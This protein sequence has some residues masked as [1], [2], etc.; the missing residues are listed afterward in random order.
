MNTI[1]SSSISLK[2]KVFKLKLQSYCK[3]NGS[4]PRERTLLSLYSYLVSGEMLP[5]ISGCLA[6]G[7]TPHCKNFLNKTSPKTEREMGSGRCDPRRLAVTLRG[8]RF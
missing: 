8:E 4:F 1:F 2:Y 3:E 7:E 5:L 6:F